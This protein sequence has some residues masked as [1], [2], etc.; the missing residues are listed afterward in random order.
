MAG[1]EKEWDDVNGTKDGG[2]PDPETLYTKEYCIGS[3]HAS[4]LFLASGARWLAAP[5]G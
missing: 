4:F 5:G 1:P 2:S 3:S